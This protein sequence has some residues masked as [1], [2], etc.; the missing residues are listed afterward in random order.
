MEASSQGRSY[1]VKGGREA[2]AREGLS[3]FTV[4]SLFLFIPVFPVFPVFRGTPSSYQPQFVVASIREGCMV[5]A[6]SFG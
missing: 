4:L 5:S 6:F 2:D 3:F 1:S